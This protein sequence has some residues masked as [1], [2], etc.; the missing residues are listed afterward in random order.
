MANPRTSTGLG[1]IPLAVSST[2]TCTRLTPTTALSTNATEAQLAALVPLGNTTTWLYAELGGEAYLIRIVGVSGNT[3]FL[4]AAA[5]NFS[6]TAYSLVD[7]KDYVSYSFSVSGNVDVMMAN[8][9]YCTT[10]GAATIADG[11][12]EPPRTY[13]TQYKIITPLV[14]DATAS[15]ITIWENKP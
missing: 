8:A 6:G 15:G 12:A 2:Y 13:A 9:G 14:F 10:S 11:Y 4:A 7:V 1:S 3:I 5:P